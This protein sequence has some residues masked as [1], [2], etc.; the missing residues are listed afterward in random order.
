MEAIKRSEAKSLGLK[1]YFTGK[2]CKNGHIEERETHGGACIGCRKDHYQRSRVKILKRIQDD[3]ER[4]LE[5]KKKYRERNRELINAKKRKWTQENLKHLAKYNKEY[6]KR[7]PERAAKW[8]RDY[9]KRNREKIY[10]TK[11]EYNDKNKLK[12]RT[13]SAARRARERMAEGTYSDADVKRMLKSQKWKCASCKARL[14]EK[15]G[16]HVDH[17]H[18][19]ALGGSNWPENLQILC[20]PCNISK[21]AKD[22]IQW[23]NENGRLL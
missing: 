14:A 10:K 11:R 20:M 12:I 15:S 7:F 5:V 3:R 8:N 19:L 22:P 4:I 17:I 2:P 23:A 18:P 6:K 21:G 1:R 13:W 9:A 16:Y